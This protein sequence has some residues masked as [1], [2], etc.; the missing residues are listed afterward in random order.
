MPI[1][2][3]EHLHDVAAQLEQHFLDELQQQLQMQAGA[4]VSDEVPMSQY[5]QEGKQL[6][7]RIADD[8]FFVGIVKK[9]FGLPP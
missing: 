5:I 3:L 7:N 4:P 9:Y 2:Q 8:G 6:P 1:F